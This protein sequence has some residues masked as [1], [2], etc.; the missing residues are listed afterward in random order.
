MRAASTDGDVLTTAEAWLRAGQDV[1]I[2]TVVETWGS[3]PR[4]VGSHLVI[5][6]EGNFEGSISGGCVEG[7][8]VTE[9]L[10]LIGRRTAKLVE[11]GVADE[12]AWQVGLSCGGRIKVHVAQI[13][14]HRPMDLTTLSSLNAERN[15]R[16]AALTVTNLAT[17]AVEMFRE[18]DRRRPGVLAAI[19][20]EGFRTGVSG[21]AAG[22]AGEPL[23]LSV[24]LPPPRLVLIG[25]VHIS[26]ALAPMARLAG[27]DVTV[28]DPRTAFATPARF[29][30]VRLLAEWPDQALGRESLDRFTAVAVLAHDPKIDDGALAAA[31]RA[32]CFYVG[33]LGS[34]KTHGKRLD[35]L[36]AIG[37]DD[38]ALA[39]IH[40]PI[41]VPI[42]ARSPAEIA[43][44]ILAE[45]I[46]A[47]RSR[48]VV[49]AEAAA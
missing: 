12:T 6:G 30:Q 28:I 15:A 24:Y 5:D 18:A 27:F 35:R 38:G 2:A 37:F 16:R 40:A 22:P 20:A 11:Y 17:G 33:A 1:A 26:Q 48:A 14:G 39:L 41:G 29:P 25:A 34:R 45:V 32:N 4:A 31:L 21:F 9:A 7:A 46:A 10:D 47:L 49:A 36:K 19:V 3:A 42:S 8:V 23:F 43:V 44:S 13:G